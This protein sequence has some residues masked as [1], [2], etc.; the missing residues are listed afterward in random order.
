MSRQFRAFLRPQHEMTVAP[1]STEAAEASSKLA[2]FS[3]F[4][5]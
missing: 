5:E 4:E 3:G 1:T 2:F